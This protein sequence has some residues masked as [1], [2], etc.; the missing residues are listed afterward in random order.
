MLVPTIH[1]EEAP[2][3]AVWLFSNTCS[4]SA[5]LR[6]ALTVPVE[7]S[8]GLRPALPVPVPNSAHRTV[9]AYDTVKMVVKYIQNIHYKNVI[10]KIYN[11]KRYIIQMC[12]RVF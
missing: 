10:Y 7:N 12:G 11:I 9:Q 6:P 5:G 1:T 3:P 2:P 8:A 4:V